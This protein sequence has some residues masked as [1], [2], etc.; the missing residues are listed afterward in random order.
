MELRY[1]YKQNIETHKYPFFPFLSNSKGTVLRYKREIVKR[2]A[3]MMLKM[4]LLTFGRASA[5]WEVER[6]QPIATAQ[7]KKEKKMIQKQ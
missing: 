1:T 7:R 4:E 6:L 5:F 3:L 2:K